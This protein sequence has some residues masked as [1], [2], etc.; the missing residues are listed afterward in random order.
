MTRKKIIYGN[1]KYFSLS[2]CH[3]SIANDRSDI[4]LTFNASNRGGSTR[5]PVA[6]PILGNF[7][8]RVPVTRHR[9]SLAIDGLRN[10]ARGDPDEH[11]RVEFGIIIGPMG[12]T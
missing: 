12:F 9:R 11:V 3:R 7:S 8:R 1:V 5:L 6:V 10:D 4:I 2:V